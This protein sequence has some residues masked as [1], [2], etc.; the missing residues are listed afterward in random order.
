[1][2]LS[3]KFRLQIRQHI[4]WA[5]AQRWKQEPDPE[6]LAD[7]VLAAF[8]GR[9]I[10]LADMLSS[11]R[12]ASCD[13]HSGP[14]GSGSGANCAACE[15]ARK[16]RHTAAAQVLQ[17]FGLDEKKLSEIDRS[18]FVT[19]STDERLLPPRLCSTPGCTNAAT[20][21]RSF[22]AGRLIPSCDLHKPSK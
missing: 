15:A 8:D 17:W 11:D 3:E 19:S 20:H 1:M 18:G 12:R 4:V 21:Y 10:V 7:A 6:E 5:I 13:L 22:A 9:I 14:D 16:Y 2:T